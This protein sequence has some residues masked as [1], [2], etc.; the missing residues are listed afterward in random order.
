MNLVGAD[1]ASALGWVVGAPAAAGCA[2]TVGM[3]S[4]FVHD[5]K[6]LAY[7]SARSRSRLSA[8]MPLAPQPITLLASSR[9]S[10]PQT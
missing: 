8:M 9:S 5:H 6:T 10:M 7:L 1:L 3:Q 4:Y 2:P